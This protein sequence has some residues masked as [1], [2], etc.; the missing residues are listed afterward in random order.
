MKKLLLA[1][2][3]LGSVA[4]EAQQKFTFVFLHKRT[5]KAEL[6]KEEVDKIMEGHM[7]N[8]NRL[9]SE[10]KLVAAGPFEGGGGLFIFNSTSQA[11]VKD[12]LQTDPGVRAERWNVEVLPYEPRIGGV[13]TVG[14]PYEMVSYTFVHFK[15]QVMKF[16]VQNADETLRKQFEFV[17][18]LA[19]TGNVVTEATFGGLDGGIWVM[20][21]DVAQET[22]LGAPA[23]V[24]SLFEPEWKKLWIAKGAFCEK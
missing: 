17:K 4:V 10:G 23:V 16:N 5:D 13:C 3:L 24:E 14:E 18:K 20:R 11:E 7:A 9:A 15:P 2:I 8:I 12:W 1:F 6:P 21:G 22:I 19:A